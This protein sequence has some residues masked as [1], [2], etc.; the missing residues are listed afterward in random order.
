MTDRYLAEFNIGVLKH[1]WDDPR[2]A[3][4][5]NNLDR[6]AG[7][8]QKS[9]GFVWML[10]DDRMEAAQLDPDGPL[11][12]NPRTASTLS[13]WKTAADLHHFTFHT[14]HKRFYDRRAEWYDPTDAPRLVMWWVDQ[15]RRPTVVEAADRLAHL[16]AHGETDHAFGWNWLRERGL[17]D[18]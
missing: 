11:G 2:V 8:G 17:I 9:R 6:V 1:D 18:G 16:A 5:A 4:F 15:T 3:D 10:S 7:V 13:V 14:V 12:G